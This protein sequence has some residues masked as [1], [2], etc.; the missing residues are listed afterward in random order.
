M[1][2]SS[3]P[4]L[5]RLLV[6]DQEGLRMFSLVNLVKMEGKNTIFGYTTRERVKNGENTQIPP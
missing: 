1:G 4:Y 5:Q 3:S 2:K 6:M